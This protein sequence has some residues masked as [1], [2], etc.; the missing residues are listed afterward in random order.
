[1]NVLTSLFLLL[2]FIVCLRASGDHDW[3]FTAILHVTDVTEVYNLVMARADGAYADPSMGMAIVKTTMT[4]SAGV[5]EKEST[6]ESIWGTPT[7]TDGTTDMTGSTSGNMYSLTFDTDAWMTIFPMKFTEAGYYAFYC[8]HYLSEFHDDIMPSYITNSEGDALMFDWVQ[9]TTVEEPEK[10]WG[11]VI[12]ATILVWIVTL[13]GLLV[14][15]LPAHLG[16]LPIDLLGK[17]GWGPTMLRYFASGALLSLAT[18]L[19]LFEA[20]HLITEGYSNEVDALWR[21][22]VMIL[23]GFITSPVCH[24]ILLFIITGFGGGKSKSNPIPTADVSGDDTGDASA[25]I[26][27]TDAAVAKAVNEKARVENVS[28]STD[29]KLINNSNV[30]IVSGLIFG[31][32]FHN[33]A[34]G[35]FIGAAFKLCDSTLAWT[36]T[37]A[38]VAHELPQ[39]ISDFTVLVNECGYSTLE[40]ILYNVLSGLSVLLGGLAITSADIDN[41]AVG[42][43]LAYG[44]GN[45]V[46]V[47]CTELFPRGEET[48]LDKEGTTAIAK[49]FFGIMTF[50]LGCIVVSLVLLDHEH[51][52]GEASGDGHA[53]A[54]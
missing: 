4:G 16:L 48:D 46:Y 45:I 39:E 51:C 3:E 12:G 24:V 52:S 43:L 17:E 35:I 29:F 47:A 49:R 10:K 41:Y 22:S 23:L 54:H 30:S 38:T 28:V 53:H 8:E 1:M 9:P 6:A 14:I 18:S 7:S 34:D 37:W 44:G 33:F 40:A 26:E 20:T 27:I 15:A 25:D 50:F 19:I 13:T 5:E 36:I 11:D 42:M 2:A 32:F 21:W 31:D